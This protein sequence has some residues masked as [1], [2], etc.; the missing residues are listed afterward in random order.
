MSNIAGKAYAMNVVTPSKP[1]LTWTNRL[2]FM[3]ARGIPG[4]LAGLLLGH[5]LRRVLHD[6]HHRGVN[7]L[8]LTNAPLVTKNGAG[9]GRFPRRLSQSVPWPFKAPWRDSCRRP[10]R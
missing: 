9:T 3:V 5:P 1:Y 8:R 6:L 10:G 7:H 4:T 2:L